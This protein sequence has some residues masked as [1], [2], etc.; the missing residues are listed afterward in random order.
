MPPTAA[1]GRYALAGRSV[2]VVPGPLPPPPTGSTE[3]P[4][5]R[6][7]PPRTHRPSRLFSAALRIR[8]DWPMYSGESRPGIQGGIRPSRVIARIALEWAFADRAVV[9]EKGA[10]P[11]TV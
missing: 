9:S 1:F 2:S 11:P 5:P 3:P 4:A 7:A 8:R 6:R 10:I